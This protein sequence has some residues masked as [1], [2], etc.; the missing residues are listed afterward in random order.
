VEFIPLLQAGRLT[1]P[2]E[3]SGILAYKEDYKQM[4]GQKRPWSK[5]LGHELG[6]AESTVSA[7]HLGLFAE[8]LGL[9]KWDLTAPVPAAY[10]PRCFRG[11]VDVTHDERPAPVLGGFGLEKGINA[12]IAISNLH[13]VF[14]G[15]RLSLMEYVADVR[16]KQGGSGHLVFVTLRQTIRRQEVGTPIVQENDM[17]TV[18]RLNGEK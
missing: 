13:P 7:E 6:K 11:R 2:R 18:Y 10:V 1:T 16:E 3:C 9:E 8:A 14:V 12:G 15:D 4:E 17:L 5:L